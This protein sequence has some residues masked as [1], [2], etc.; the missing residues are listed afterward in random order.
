[1][2]LQASA[3]LVAASIGIYGADAR[4]QTTTSTPTVTLS[5]Q[6][7]VPLR[8][9]NNGQTLIT[10]ARPSNLNPA[11]VNY[12]DCIQDL[13]L[14]WSVT[15]G[16]FDGSENMQVWAGPG[17][18][19]VDTARGATAAGAVSATCWEVNGGVT[20][21]VYQ[22][23]QSL[24]F[25]VR[26]QDLV[27]PQD[28]P[29]FPVTGPVHEGA[30]ACSSQLSFAAVPLNVW[31]VPVNSVGQKVGNALSIPIGTDLVGP[32]P[33]AVNTPGVGDTLLIASWTANIDSDT[34]G[35]DVFIDPK[36]GSSV[37]A[38][39]ASAT[40]TT[41]VTL[42]CEEAGTATASGDD[43]GGDDTS[44]GDDGSTGDDST[45]GDATGDDT[46]A[47]D[48]SSVT[49]PEA[50]ATT[51]TGP[52]CYYQAVASTSASAASGCTS[53]IL[54]SGTVQDAG[55][56]TTVVAY[57]DAGN[58]I[59]SGV[60][61]TGSGGIAT[62]PCD[63]LVGTSCPSGSPVYTSTNESVSGES[64]ASFTI[65]GLIDGRLYNVAVSAV[66]DYGNVGPPSTEVCATPEPVADFFQTYRQ[67]GG[68]AG[69]GF[70]S[71]LAPGLPV[72]A[73]AAILTGLGV[74]ASGLGRRRTRR[75]RNAAA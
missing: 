40:P 25:W 7:V 38:A 39:L 5:G 59:D 46:G 22:T 6:G 32:P 37:D 73:S 67:D 54:S 60:T 16:G 27:G 33:P 11:G 63:Y 29:P 10:T 17:D 53:T 70:C 48:D 26:V 14:Q 41:T 58:V 66:D 75:R 35:Y 47:G 69:G 20:Q 64:N 44:T 57:D 31:F 51:P 74:A 45:T 56:S 1:M 65:S 71:V 42:I 55:T 15:L 8:Y 23:P 43:G 28:A 34:G 62:V 13:W 36:P 2:R 19:S 9:A 4:A 21:T 3:V 68:G 61:T 72:G 30:S 52:N 50:A 24:T 18:C 49:V 12:D